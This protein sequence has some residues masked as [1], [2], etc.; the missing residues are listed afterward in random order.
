[1]DQNWFTSNSVGRPPNDA[2]GRGRRW[3]TCQHSTELN[4]DHA[5]SPPNRN[6]GKNALAKANIIR[7]D[8]KDILPRIATNSI[9]SIITDP[10]Y[11]IQFFNREWDDNL[12]PVQTWRECF[13]V[14]KPGGHL[15]A[16]GAT[17]TFHRLWSTIEDAEFQIRDTLMWI[18]GSGF[19]KSK[20]V[21]VM[22][23]KKLGHPDRGHRIAV[24]RSRHHPD[25]SAQAKRRTSRTIRGKVA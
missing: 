24:A 4:L 20:N 1:M 16:F 5:A 8:S 22:L 25:G 10:P 7:G 13:R 3:F 15:L 12:P 11:G 21:A 2:T 17:R 9:N 14:L 6:D 18:F 23:D 19:P